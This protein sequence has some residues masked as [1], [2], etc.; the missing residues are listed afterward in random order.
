MPRCEIAGSYGSSIFSF[1][2]KLHIVKLNISK[3]K[4]MIFPLLISSLLPQLRKRSLD[5][6][7]FKP[8]VGLYI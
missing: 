6:Q 3:T 7:L 2:R 8:D 4:L 1:L 5:N